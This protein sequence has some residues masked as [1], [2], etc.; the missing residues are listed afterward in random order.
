MYSFTC[1]ISTERI[2]FDWRLW[3]KHFDSFYATIWK[4]KNCRKKAQQTSEGVIWNFSKTFILINF[5]S[6]IYKKKVL[7]NLKFINNISSTWLLYLMYKPWPF[8]IS[9]KAKF[10]LVKIRI[11]SNYTSIWLHDLSIIFVKVKVIFL[12]SWIR[13]AR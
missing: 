8:L 4:K 9:V 7:D 2:N 5:V 1:S 10:K 12:L 6:Q 13:I 3:I 11:P